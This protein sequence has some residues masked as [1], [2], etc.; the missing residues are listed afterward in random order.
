M[1]IQPTN[2]PTRYSDTVCNCIFFTLIALL[3]S[4]LQRASTANQQEESVEDATPLP[5]AV[6]TFKHQ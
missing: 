1:D 6:V 4:L 5:F 3:L 2:Q